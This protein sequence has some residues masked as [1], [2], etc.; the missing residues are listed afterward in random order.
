MTSPALARMATTGIYLLRGVP[1]V[2]QRTARARAVHEGTT[3]RQVLV[4]ALREYAAGTWTPRSDVES[5]ET[6]HSTSGASAVG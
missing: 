3:L 6:A 1:R 4:Q 5:R 2:L